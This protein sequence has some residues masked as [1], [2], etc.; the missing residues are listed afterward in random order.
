MVKRRKLLVV[1]RGTATVA[2]MGSILQK[3][4]GIRDNAP[5]NLGMPIARSRELA[6]RR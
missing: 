3:L 4:R 1:K 2:K 6:R 5:N